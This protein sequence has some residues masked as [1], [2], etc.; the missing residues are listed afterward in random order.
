MIPG[1]AFDDPSFSTSPQEIKP[2][3]E[4][5]GDS[6]EQNQPGQFSTR[7]GTTAARQDSASPY[8][9]FGDRF[10]PESALTVLD[11]QENLP[12]PPRAETTATT[13]NADTAQ[14]PLKNTQKSSIDEKDNPLDTDG[15]G[16]VS[17]AEWLNRDEATAEASASGTGAVNATRLADST[18][19]ER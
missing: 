7:S 2:A 11:A 8:M 10:S 18:D 12:A 6:K 17:F 9:N 19:G 5:D 16:M 14:P 4:I 3:A 15:D 13:G 1:V